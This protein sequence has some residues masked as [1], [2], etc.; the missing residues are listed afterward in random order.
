MHTA[1]GGA[2]LP[3]ALRGTHP[4]HHDGNGQEAV[5]ARAAFRRIQVAVPSGLA[6]V[7][8]QGLH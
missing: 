5:Q 7:V 8:D 4:D 3:D 6:G 1:D 2:E